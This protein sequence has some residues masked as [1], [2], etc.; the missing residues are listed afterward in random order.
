VT[1]I[2]YNSVS[3]ITSKGD[4]DYRKEGIIAVQLAFEEAKTWNKKKLSSGTV[5]EIMKVET[6]LFTSLCTLL[7][8]VE[9]II[10][11]LFHKRMKYV[12]LSN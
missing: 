9:T 1:Q 5:F 8:V 11:S 7:A 6:I 4:T 3:V 2:S 10:K 12:C